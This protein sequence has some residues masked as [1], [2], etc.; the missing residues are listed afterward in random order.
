LFQKQNGYG[1]GRYV[2]CYSDEAK[3]KYPKKSS[4]SAEQQAL[5]L[6]LM[7]KYA[8]KHSPFPSQM[9]QKELEQYEVC[10]LCIRVDLL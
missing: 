10:T 7:V 2:P 1:S 8:K 6:Q 9:E 3:V 4:L 5:Y